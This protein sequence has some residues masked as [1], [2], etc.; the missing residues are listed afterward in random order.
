MSQK[1]S[2]PNVE[3]AG[4]ETYLVYG[5]RTCGTLSQEVVSG[6]TDSPTGESV[7]RDNLNSFSVKHHVDDDSAGFGDF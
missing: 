1:C 5:V 3:S 7:E 4:C 2:N 6:S